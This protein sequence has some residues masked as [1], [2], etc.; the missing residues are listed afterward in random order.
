MKILVNLSSED[1]LELLSNKRRMRGSIALESPHEASFHRHKTTSRPKAQ[2]YRSKKLGRCGRVSM[3][4]E[5]LR[6]NLKIPVNEPGWFS[7]YVSLRTYCDKAC[8]WADDEEFY[9]FCG[10]REDENDEA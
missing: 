6:L 2:N 4:D 5:D 1:Y 3:S 8:K 7:P 10:Y 9:R